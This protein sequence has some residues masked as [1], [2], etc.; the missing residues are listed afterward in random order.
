MAYD[1]QLAERVR[2]ALKR[3]RGVGERKMFGG[4]CFTVN[5][6]MCCGVTGQNLV[7]RL[8][9]EGAAT[10]LNERHTRPMDFTGRPMKSMVYVAPAG[11]HS[12][13]DLSG[14]LDRALRFARGLPPK[15]RK[16]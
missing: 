8:G 13:K 11:T 16:G 5:G 3:R 2:K 9:N 7:V 15:R 12:D 1:V 10:A 4:V 6:N 14:W